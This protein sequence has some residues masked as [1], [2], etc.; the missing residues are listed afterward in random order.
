[1]PILPSSSG[2]AP[3]WPARRQL[4]LAGALAGL[5]LAAGL[6][7]L[8]Q[9]SRLA[10]RLARAQRSPGLRAAA[11]F[12][13]TRYPAEAGVDALVAKLPFAETTGLRTLG[14]TLLNQIEQDF[15]RHDVEFV[16]GWIFARTELRLCLL[17]DLLEA[18]A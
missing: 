11:A 7:A 5:G 15:A 1:M 2:E 3:K 16:D 14:R 8:A 12:Y 17:S 18:R 10:V 4:V 13:R 9:G 6:P